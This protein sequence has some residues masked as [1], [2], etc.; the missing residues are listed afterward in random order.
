MKLDPYKK[1]ALFL[2]VAKV[3][4]LEPKGVV[5]ALVEIS[6]NDIVTIKGF[7]VIQGDGE[8]EVA[9]PTMRNKA[10]NSISSTV[11]FSDQAVEKQLSFIILAVYSK[12]LQQEELTVG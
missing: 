5:L 7:K 11:L 2:K 12:L 6:I 4:K 9:G 8:L 10:D 3:T 1:E